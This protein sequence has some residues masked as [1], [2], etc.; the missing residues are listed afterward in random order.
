MEEDTHSR[1]A[2]RTSRPES[3]RIEPSAPWA[4][5]GGARIDVMPT[6]VIGG[7]PAS[8]VDGGTLQCP[9]LLFYDAVEDLQLT[10]FASGL[11]V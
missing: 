5:R 3:A 4:D 7:W 10:S 11:D 1:Q 6:T 8:N 2:R 9:S